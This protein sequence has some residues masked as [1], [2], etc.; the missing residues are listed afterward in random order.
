MDRAIDPQLAYAASDDFYFTLGKNDGTVGGRSYF[1]ARRGHGLFARPHAVQVDAI[2]I[3]R[4][5]TGGGNENA[6]A[7]RG[8]AKR[9]E[10]A[11]SAPATPSS[12][13]R[14]GG[15]D[16]SR[17]RRRT[18]SEDGGASRA[19]ADV[20]GR[21]R[22][23]SAV[24]RLGVG[25]PKKAGTPDAVPTARRPPA[26][27]RRWKSASNLQPGTRRATEA[28]AEDPMVGQ[29]VL[30]NG[31][32]LGVARVVSATKF[33]QGTWVGV[34]LDEATEGG[35]NGSVGG[36]AYF[37]C[38][39]GHGKFVRKA[40]IEVVESRKARRSSSSRRHRGQTGSD[41]TGTGGDDPSTPEQ[42]KASRKI[43]RMHGRHRGKPPTGSRPP[44]RR[45][46]SVKPTRS[47]K[48]AA[49]K[50]AGR[51]SADGGRQR[52]R[53]RSGRRRSGAASEGSP[54]RAGQARGPAASSSASPD[55]PIPSLVALKRVTVATLASHLARPGDS[56]RRRARAAFRWIAANVS[57]DEE[58]L[59]LEES[60]PDTVSAAAV[61][62]DDVL[63][64]RTALSPGFAALYA[65]LGMC[66]VFAW[67]SFGIRL[68][69][70]IGPVAS[71]CHQIADLFPSLLLRLLNAVRAMGME[72]RVVVGYCKLH[73]F[74]PG[75]PVDRAGASHAWNIVTIDGV[76]SIV[77]C[78]WTMGE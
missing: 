45:T 26:P 23:I 64:R 12:T 25:A 24:V 60:H 51:A 17:R 55:R 35:H 43:D 75:V 33:A 52:R 15:H 8:K 48:G 65:A 63:D 77:D 29:R 19:G 38:R 53:L 18:A 76:D 5:E 40:A 73:N 74:E 58:A 20:K 67:Y 22:P 34:E 11:P 39:D 30:V 62:P 6:S 16:R 31:C 28:P 14:R 1:E 13:R 72:A 68:V 78:A 50:N 41:G 32:L 70:E 36:V 9:R 46:A 66:L 69:F 56:E 54:G 27:L 37:S 44:Q 2:D 71:M 59:A 61:D 4:T 7:Q 42:V 3:E 57:V 47:T 10:R 21:L 49:E